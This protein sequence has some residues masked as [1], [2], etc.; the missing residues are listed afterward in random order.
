ME[1]QTQIQNISAYMF[2]QIEEPEK[3]LPIL[4]EKAEELSLKGTILLSK[5]GI[6]LF[7]AAPAA[8]L[9]Q[10]LDFLRQDSYLGSDF[11]KKLVVGYTNYQPFGRMV[12]R[13]VKEIIT[14]RVPGIDP[15]SER[16]PWV[17]PEK[18]K[19][20]LDQ[21][22]D[23]EGREIVMLDTRNLFEVEMGTFDQAEYLNIDKFSQF[24]EAIKE[25]VENQPNLKDKTIVSFCTGG[26]RCEK[27]ALYLQELD[28][29]K[30]YQ[31]DGGILGYFDKVGGSHWQGECFVFDDRIALS[32]DLKETKKDYAGRTR[33]NT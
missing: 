1:I 3:W 28:L 23:D 30:V 26:I 5:E 33:R 14:M 24:P 31:L 11:A 7:L 29:P 18:L 20:W 32:P 8:D 21:G 6:N 25:L 9:N 16:A 10:F 2:R 15:E 12:V 27:A 13:M 17:Q 22:T 19:V 4:K